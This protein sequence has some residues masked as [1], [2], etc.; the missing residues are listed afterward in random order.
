MKGL[1]DKFFLSFA[2][3]KYCNQR[4][5]LAIL[6]TS[7]KQIDMKKIFF[8]SIIFTLLLNWASCSKKDANDELPVNLYKVEVYE[9]NTNMPVQGASVKLNHCTKYDF[10]FGCQGIGVFASYP[11]GSDGIASI[12]EK[13]YSKC[14]K[15]MVIEKSGYW[16]Q[17]GTLGRNEINAEGWVEATFKRVHDYPLDKHFFLLDSNENYRVTSGPWRKMVDIFPLR[18]TTIKFKAFGGQL[19]H[20]KWIVGEEYLVLSGWSSG[21][22]DY[23]AFTENTLSPLSVNKNGITAIN[24]DY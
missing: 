11:T 19:N 4:S 14:D 15:G 22:M 12:S 20:L 23:N 18:D 13:D 6:R 3:S 17:D 7:L 16:S 5:Q 8:N 10:E 9:Y 21:Y 1:H 24:I 2:L